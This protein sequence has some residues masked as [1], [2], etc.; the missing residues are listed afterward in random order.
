MGCFGG[1]CND[2]SE[3]I[4][5]SESVT[6]VCS[7]PA[8]EPESLPAFEASENNESENLEVSIELESENLVVSIEFESV[9]SNKLFAVIGP[10]GGYL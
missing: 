9:F 4:N 1:S 2:C 6:F 10:G 5:V 7:L 3:G 8:F